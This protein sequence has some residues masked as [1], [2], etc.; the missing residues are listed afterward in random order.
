MSGHAPGTAWQQPEPA[1]T[2][3]SEHGCP[4]DPTRRNPWNR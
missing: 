1:R 4:T 2:F 3:L